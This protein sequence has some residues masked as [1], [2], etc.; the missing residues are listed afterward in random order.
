MEYTNNAFCGHAPEMPDF[1]FELKFSNTLSAQAENMIKYKKYISEPLGL[2]FDGLCDTVLSLGLPVV[3][4]PSRCIS[5]PYTD[6]RFSPGVPL[7]EYMYIRFKAEDRETDIPGLYFDMGSE[8]YG[9]GIR[10]Y[11]QTAQGMDALRKKIHESF[12]ECSPLLDGLPSEGFKVIGTKFKKDR[13][14]DI[15]ESPAKEILNSREFRIE[16]ASPLN[17]RVFTSALSDELSGVFTKLAGVFK[18][19]L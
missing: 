12:R 3:T 13:F 2:L 16:R 1:L 17:E 8:Y 14:P 10:I 9:C 5:T 6:R 18:L 15:P 4:K 11:K 19:F 7:K